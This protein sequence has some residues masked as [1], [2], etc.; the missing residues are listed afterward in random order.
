MHGNRETLETPPSDG[1]GGRFGKALGQT[2]NMYAC[3]PL[4]PGY[5]LL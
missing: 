4:A 3:G 2:P 5:F 1:G